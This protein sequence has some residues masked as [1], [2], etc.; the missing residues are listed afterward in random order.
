MSEWPALAAVELLVAVAE[1]GSLA[2]GARAVGVAQPNASRSIVRL[3][4]HLK[5]SLLQRSTSGSTLTPAGML[6]VEWSRSLLFAARNLTE[7]A[8]A[9]AADGSGS[10]TVSA[11]Q[12]VAEHLLPRWLSEL[13]WTHPGVR[14][15][16]Q[17]HNTHDVLEDV[18]N[19]RCAVGFTEGPDAPGGVH[20]LVV[21]RDEL[22]LVVWPA[23]PWANRHRPVDGVELS[24]TPLVTRES[25]SGTRVAL[26]AVL[27]AP[28]QSVL[29]LSSNAAVRVSVMSGTAPA[30]LSRLA[31]ADAL[32]AGTLHEV[33]VAGLDLRRPLRAA[34]TGP[35]RLTGA[36]ADLVAVA[37][38]TSRARGDAYGEV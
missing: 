32:A 9:L 28:V 20:S 33:P 34:W 10:M 25:G 13:R 38:A 23:H 36:A 31:V 30:V 37:R 8:A 11:S 35:R 15:T 5:L 27:G 22:V 18:L 17:V 7:G 12:T 1:H 19:G 3:E 16:V 29:E 2:A 14:I 24:S 26:D 4:R 21:A 6:I